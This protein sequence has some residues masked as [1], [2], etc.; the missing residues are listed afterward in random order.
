M[1]THSMGSYGRYGVYSVNHTVPLLIN[2]HEVPGNSRL[3]TLCHSS[4]LVADL[5]FYECQESRW[6]TW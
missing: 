4:V 6:Y 1:G 5:C 3:R 2:Q